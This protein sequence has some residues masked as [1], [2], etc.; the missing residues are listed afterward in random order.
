M[1]KKLHISNIK[2]RVKC[3]IS[4]YLVTKLIISC[5]GKSS[6]P[7]VPQLMKGLVA[8]GKQGHTRV[9]EPSPIQ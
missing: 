6:N 1:L 2:Q 4:Y 3:A 9:V 5:S 7:T 8:S